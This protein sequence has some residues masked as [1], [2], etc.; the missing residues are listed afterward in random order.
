MEH[1][2]TIF[3]FLKIELISFM[4]IVGTTVALIFTGSMIYVM[5]ESAFEDAGRAGE[6]W[7]TE[8]H[9]SHTDFSPCV[10]IL[11]AWTAA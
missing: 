10:D 6:A 4:A 2:V 7:K 5:N 3:F 8:D 11:I 9:T 1:H